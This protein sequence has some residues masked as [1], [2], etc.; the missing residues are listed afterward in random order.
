M[1]PQPIGGRIRPGF[2]NGFGASPVYFIARP[3]VVASAG[4]ND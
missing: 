2:S 3:F 4:Q 1:Q